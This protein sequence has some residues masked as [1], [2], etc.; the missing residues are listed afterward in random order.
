[1]ITR[2]SRTEK[3]RLGYQTFCCSFSLETRLGSKETRVLA[4][5]KIVYIQREE[6][7]F[8]EGLY[9]RDNRSLESPH[10]VAD[11]FQDSYVLVS[12]FEFQ[13]LYYFHFQANIHGKAMAPYSQQQ[14]ID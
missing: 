14:A 8:F 1:M 12:E 10:G 9:Y 7:Y 4:L 6:L 11:N 13:S 5:L 3:D 2:I